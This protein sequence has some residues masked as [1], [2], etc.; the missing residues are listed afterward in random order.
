MN[1]THEYIEGETYRADIAVDEGDFAVLRGYD[2]LLFAASS[3]NMTVLAN[4]LIQEL[5]C[6]H[7]GA[8]SK[9]WLRGEAE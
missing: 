7:C 5:K 2:D 4:A 9:G 1:C 6:K 3:T 8:V